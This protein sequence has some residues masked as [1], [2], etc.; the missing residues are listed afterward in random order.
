MNPFGVETNRHN[1]EV[2]IGYADQQGLLHRRLD[3]DELYDDTTRAL[4]S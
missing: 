4:A 1:L 2:A 3:V